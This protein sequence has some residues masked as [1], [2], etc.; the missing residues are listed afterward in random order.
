MHPSVCVPK[1]DCSQL[2]LGFGDSPGIL[3]QLRFFPCQWEQ[4]SSPCREGVVEQLGVGTGGSC[5]VAGLSLPLCPGAADVSA[6]F[7]PTDGFG[8]VASCSIHSKKD[9]KKLQSFLTAGIVCSSCQGGRCFTGTG[10]WGILAS[11]ECHQEAGAGH[12]ALGRGQWQP[13][14]LWAAPSTAREH[15]QCQGAG[16]SQENAPGV[17]MARAVLPALPGKG[18]S[19]PARCQPSSSSAPAWGLS[20]WAAAGVLSEFTGLRE[21]PGKQHIPVA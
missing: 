3:L 17:G 1:S 8:A 15:R 7:S 13:G 20:H 21:F 6:Q 11:W 4:R 14:T 12:R 10:S 5:G 19:H 18:S 16:D 9:K 2:R